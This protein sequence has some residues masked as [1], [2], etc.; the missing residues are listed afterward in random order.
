MHAQDSDK[1][2]DRS[3]LRPPT[4]HVPSNALN[5]SVLPQAAA[6]TPDSVAVLQRKAGNEAV[7]RTLQQQ[8]HQHSA[9]ATVQRMV[10]TTVQ[11]SP[12]DDTSG[13]KEVLEYTHVAVDKDGV[14]LDQL[15][16]SLNA[17]GLRTAQS[18]N[19][20]LSGG[21]EKLGHHQ[22]V[23]MWDARA[24]GIEG[25]SKIVERVGQDSSVKVK[26]RRA[27]LTEPG[28]LSQ[29]TLKGDQ[30]TGQLGGKSQNGAW[31]Y[32]GDIP[33]KYL[34]I[35]GIDQVNQPGFADWLAG[36]GWPDDHAQLIA[37]RSQ[38]QEIP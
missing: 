31:A 37:H 5:P 36:K 6:L 7:S 3:N 32:E 19:I 25:A 33:R 35:E 34:F 38:Y 14:G 26:I 30:N 17:N 4:S 10:G 27:S 11:R 2:T 28:F 20:K 15:L 23:F 22:H 9:H 13:G 1:A 29:G 16:L 21:S 18:L 12:A 8:T 24:K